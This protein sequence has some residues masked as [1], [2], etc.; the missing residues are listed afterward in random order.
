M[1]QTDQKNMAEH[2]VDEDWPLWSRRMS[3]RGYSRANCS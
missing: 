3:G 2:V 1:K